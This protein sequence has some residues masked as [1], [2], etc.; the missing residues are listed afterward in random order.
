M[1]RLDPVLHGGR[2]APG[3]LRRDQLETFERDGLL[4]LEG[5]FSP[6]EVRELRREMD[7]L[8]RA[9]ERDDERLVRELGSGAVRSI[10]AIHRMEGA[11]ADLTMDARLADVARQLLAEEVYIHQSRVNYKPGFVGKPFYWHSDFE[12][13][14]VEDG[15]PRMRAV[16]FSILLADNHPHNGPLMWIPGSHRTYV[17]CAGTTPKNNHEKSLR[18]QQIGVPDHA[19]LTRLVDEGGIELAEGGEG[20]LV[21]FECNLMHG[22][23]SNLSPDPRSNAFFVYNALSNRLVRP[24]GGV[25]PRP[26]FLAEREPVPVGIHRFAEA[27]E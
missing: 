14:H 26:G 19:S 5:A 27:A 20:T 25:H 9:L 1:R 12:T 13:W 18:D 4:R 15:M 21:I 10:F 24:F 11:F 3:P 23:G 7:R 8:G 6:D 16:S 22:S 2:S 17:G